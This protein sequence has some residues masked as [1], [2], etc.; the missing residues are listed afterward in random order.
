MVNSSR[1][2]VFQAGQPFPLYKH[3]SLPTR[4]ETAENVSFRS[5]FCPICTLRSLGLVR[6]QLLQIQLHINAPLSGIEGEGSRD[7]LNTWYKTCDLH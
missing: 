4:D 1:G 2:A 3:F 5:P 7:H 6:E